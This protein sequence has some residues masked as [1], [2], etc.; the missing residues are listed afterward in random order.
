MLLS[1]ADPAISEGRYHRV[2]GPGAWYSSDQEQAA[3]AELFRHFPDAGVDPFQVR[4]RIGKVTVSNLEVLDLTDGAIGTVVGL[5]PKDLV[6]DDY[7]QSQAVA[8]AASEAGFGGIIA[9]SAALPGRMTLVVFGSGMKH[10]TPGSSRIRQPPP[11]LVDLLRA[12]RPS[13]DVPLAV[14]NRLQLVADAGSDVLRR[15]RRGSR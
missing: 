11:R 3:W 12:V 7:T 10:L 13:P 14:I 5:E 1:F 4:R 2:G 6:G 8:H 9:P 15:R